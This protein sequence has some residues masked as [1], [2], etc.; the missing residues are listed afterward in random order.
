MSVGSTPLN[1]RDIR[2][3]FADAETE[4]VEEPRL[5]LDGFFDPSS[6]I[7]SALKGREFLFLGYKGSGKSSISEH[8][9]LSTEQDP[10]IFVTQAFLSDFPYANL[11]NIVR[12]VVDPEARYPSAWT[13][14]LL[15]ALFGSF[16]KDKGAEIES[17]SEYSDALKVLKNNGFLPTPSLKE[18]VRVSS[19]KSFRINLKGVSGATESASTEITHDLLTFI[20]RLR[21][22]TSQIKTTSTHLLVIDGL[23]E[24]LS[25]SEVQYQSLAALVGEV[26]R[27]NSF[28][29]RNGTPA[30]IVVL[31]R[32][33]LFERLP[34]ANKNKLR[35]DS[36]FSLDWYH[37][38]RDPNNSMLVH[39]ANRRAKLSQPSIENVFAEYFPDQLERQESKHFLLDLTRHT[40]RDFLQLLNRI[41]KFSEHGRLTRDQV[42]NGVRQYSIEYFLP[43]IRDEM[44]GYI[45][46]E[47]V[48]ATF[49]LIGSLRKRD[50]KL[51]ELLSKASGQERFE[52][53]DL[54]NIIRTLFEASA[55][56]N[57]HNR[58][59]GTT[60]Y[61][62][63]FRNRNST[64][65]L[66]DGLILH[67]GMW[68]AM[69][70][71]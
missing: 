4:S 10:Q 20:E 35:Q 34:S 50:F 47:D 68:K 49:D 18:V 55:I 19:K 44:H 3:G 16:D 26:G 2:F 62:F 54:P 13:W 45:K 9:R 48:D 17:S 8:L 56:G 22:I 11:K 67:R 63:R 33:D 58:P 57:I 12:G 52:R 53:L 36:A 21:Q 37:D 65:N 41:Q 71:V 5:L 15:L 66:E 24:I 31:C 38:S 6:M 14:L 32:T 70:L 46:R 28:F 43:E 69:N 25:A 23:D 40:P 27:L 64:L 1:F 51:S 30:K 39:L 59:G 60:L 29:K 42:L 7:D 61:T